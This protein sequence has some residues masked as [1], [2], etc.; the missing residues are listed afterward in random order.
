MAEKNER[1]CS[2][3]EKS[4][5]LYYIKEQIQ[6]CGLCEEEY[7]WGSMLKPGTLVFDPDGDH[8]SSPPPIF[9]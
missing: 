1:D 8:P 9:R 5:I 2:R 6:L 4:H 7:H 3:C